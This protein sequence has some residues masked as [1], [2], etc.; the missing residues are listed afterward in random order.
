MRKLVV[1]LAVLGAATFAVA[2]QPPKPKPADKI[3][4]EVV[5]ITCY[6][7]H[8]AHGEKHA[9]CAQKCLAA[10]MPAGIVADGKLYVATMKDHSSPNT[11][12]AAWAGKLVT[13]TGAKLEKDGLRVFEIETVE[14]K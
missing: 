7:S 8:E 2:Q 11:K 6:A 1:A 9:A 3:T 13:A 12:L 5:D 4:G 10:G 14:A